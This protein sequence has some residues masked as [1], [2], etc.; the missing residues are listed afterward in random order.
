MTDSHGP[1]VPRASVTVVQSSMRDL[2]RRRKRRTF[3]KTALGIVLLVVLVWWGNE[4]IVGRPVAEALAADPTA[5]KIGLSAHL[6][7]RVDLSTLVLVLERTDDSIPELPFYALLVVAR[8]MH[9]AEQHFARVVLAGEDGAAYVISGA[10]FDRLGGAFPG[11]GNPVEWAREV[12][13][14]LRSPGGS[15]ALGPLAGALPPVLGMQPMEAAAAAQRWL[16]GTH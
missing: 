6:L 15:A 10:D 8:R 7:Y 4:F 1:R 16:A 2:R 14:V 12:P 9:S 13:P 5:A 3:V 11:A